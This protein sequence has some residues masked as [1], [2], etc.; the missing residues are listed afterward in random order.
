MRAL[1][2]VADEAEV[3]ERQARHWAHRGWVPCKW[4]DAHGE[5]VDEGGSGYRMVLDE[6]GQRL[7]LRMAQL[8]RAGFPP[9]RAS[10]IARP[11]AAGAASVRLCE[12]LVLVREETPGY[13]DANV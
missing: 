3:T 2:D 5:A 9:E 8:V 6:F 12:G 1:A 11:L 4:E 13:V 10:E 7:L